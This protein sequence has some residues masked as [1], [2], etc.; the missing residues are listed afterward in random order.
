VIGQHS[1]DWQP[2]TGAAVA[3]LPGTLGVYEIADEAG[4]VVDIGYAGAH[5]VFGLRTVLTPWL[6][7]PGRW[8]FCYEVTS[9]YL[10]RFLELA[11]VH[12]A[13]HGDLPE[14]VRAR[15]EPV[16]GRLQT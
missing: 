13:H 12:Q 4:T 6:S 8:Q 11:M 1:I 2:L 7:K 9:A 16:I 14:L 3:E 5:A 15:R 10:T